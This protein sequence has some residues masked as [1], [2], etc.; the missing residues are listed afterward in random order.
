MT[1]TKRKSL[2]TILLALTSVSVCV[3]QVP[4][5]QPTLWSFLGITQGCRKIHGTLFNRQRK[6]PGFGKEAAAIGYCRPS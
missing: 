2:L 5:P 3:A 6:S 1:R 4:P